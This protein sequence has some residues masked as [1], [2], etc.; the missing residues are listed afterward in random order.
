MKDTNLYVPVVTLS[1]IDNQKVSK[2]F[3]EIFERSVYWNEYKPK[4][5]NEIRQTNITL[6]ESNFVGVNR[7]FVL[8]CSSQDINFKRFKTRRYFSPKGI[9]NNYNVVINGNKFY[10]QTIDPDIKKF[11]SF[12]IWINWL[13]INFSIENAVIIINNSFL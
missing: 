9:I 4:S 13:V 3:S 6:L 1:A 12:Y 10:D 7:L 2:L 11:I 5:G 8:V